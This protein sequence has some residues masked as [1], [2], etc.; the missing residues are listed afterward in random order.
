MIKSMQIDKQLYQKV[1]TTIFSF[2]GK[3]PILTVTIYLMLTGNLAFWSAFQKINTGSFL[4]TLLFTVSFF[5]FIALFIAVLLYL[6]R[7]KYV[8]K[9]ILVFILIASSFA[10]YFMT[11]YGVMID[12]TMIYNLMETDSSEAG[13]L[14]STGLIL[15]VFLF[16][17]LPSILI[18]K[19]RI[20]YL[21]P[22]KQAFRNTVAIGLFIAIFIGNFLMF[23]SHYAS[24][25]RNHHHVRYLINPV[26]YVY[27]IG[28]YLSQTLM[29]E[30]TTA[31]QIGMD[32]HVNKDI[33][34][35][36]KRSV[37]VLVVG[38]T[39]RAMNFS[40]NGYNKNTNPLLANED[41]LNYP[42]FYSCGTS[43]H[44]SLPCMF[45]MFGR[46]D[47][48]EA[49]AKY[50][51]KLPDVLQ[52]AG[53]D[54]SWRDNNSGCKGVCKN[55][56]TENTNLINLDYVCSDSECYDE[57][58]LVGLKDIIKAKTKN[59]VIILHQKGSHGPA[60][61]L[62]H[63]ST[64]QKFIPECETSELSNCS[65]NEI[66]NAYDNTILYTDHFLAKVIS[67]LKDEAGEIDTAMLY[68]SDHGESL[69]ENH[70]YLHSLPYLIAPEDQKHVPFITWFSD[71]FSEHNLL[72][73]TCLKKNVNNAYSHDNLFHS[74]L[75]LTHVSTSIYKPELDIYRHCRKPISYL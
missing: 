28:K 21:S 1:S 42:N 61:Y 18:V 68:V 60:Y 37:I 45:S 14:I 8:L 19:S 33:K 7:F 20:Y 66:T 32:A 71:S 41:I 59:A 57:A 64:F 49:R 29:V 67:L 55:I 72:D 3:Y 9:P 4:N 2:A 17:V 52:R 74:I 47:F 34:M 40:L 58:M 70:V 24:F 48:D 25:F 27:S 36:K 13:D 5:I 30:D 51:E 65:T 12:T 46:E 16:G 22:A 56:P 39:A 23:S 50:F 69:G 75:G 31:V 43:T 35:I 73:Q 62:R 11:N 44:V 6:V 10:S 38:E 26:N 53:I 15:H 63:P 54:V